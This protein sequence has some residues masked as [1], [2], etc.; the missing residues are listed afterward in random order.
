MR[1]DLGEQLFSHLGSKDEGEIHIVKPMN[2]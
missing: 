2:N 1:N